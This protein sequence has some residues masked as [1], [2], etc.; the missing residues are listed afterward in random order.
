MAKKAKTYKA[1]KKRFRIT[2]TGKVM[3]RAQKDNSHLKANKSRAQKARTKKMNVLA[4]KKQSN[5]IKSLLNQ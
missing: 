3:H 2:R 5:K 4:D 1:A